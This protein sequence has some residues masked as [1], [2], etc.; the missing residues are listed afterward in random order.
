MESGLGARKIELVPGF[1]D[2]PFSSFTSSPG[3]HHIDFRGLLGCCG[4][5]SHLIV[6]DLGV[7]SHYRNQPQGRSDPVPQL[8]HFE[9]AKEGDVTGQDAKF[10]QTLLALRQ[11]P[12]FR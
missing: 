3:A 12:P 4:Q 8:S 7:A 10:A 1:G 11:C 9:L 2:S 5:N 6:S